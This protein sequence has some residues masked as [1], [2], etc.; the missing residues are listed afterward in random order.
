MT[1]EQREKYLK[2]I[3]RIE[4]MKRPEK[5]RA[6]RKLYLALWP[7][8]VAA[9]QAHCEALKEYRNAVNATNSSKSLSMRG[10]MKIPLYVYN[11]LKVLDPELQIEWSGKNKG[12][13]EKINKQLWL[14]FPEY[15]AS[16]KY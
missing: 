4:T 3:E 2:A 6:I 5:W 14:A 11:A 16:R 1:P 12:L 8:L 9:D 15:R 13:Q 10:S 7:E